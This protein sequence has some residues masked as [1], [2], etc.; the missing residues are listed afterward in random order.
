MSNDLTQLCNDYKQNI[1][2]DLTDVDNLEEITNDIYLVYSQIEPILDLDKIKTIIRNI[3]LEAPVIFQPEY[4]DKDI[5]LLTKQI[6]ELKKIKQPEQRT[7]EWH[8]F[9]NN[10]LTASDLGTALKKNKYSTR[11]KLVAKK[12]GYEEP[13]V[14]GEAIRHG[15]KYEDVAIDIYARRNN[16]VVHEYGCIPHPTLPY[17]GA[18]P[19]GICD[20]SSNNKNYIGR[21]LE[22]KCPKSRPITGIIPEHY[23][24]QVQGQLEVCELQYCDYLEC[25][26]KEYPGFI[27]FLDD[28]QETIT[29]TKNNMEKGIIIELY[30][31]KDKKAFYF[32]LNNFNSQKDIEKWE[33]SKISTIFND[34]NIEYTGTTYWYL[35]KYSCVLVE[36]DIPRFNTIKEHI[37]TFWDDVLKYREIGFESLITKKQIIK[38]NKETKYKFFKKT[39]ELTFLPDS[40]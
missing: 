5:Q 7:P 34:D 16:V 19:D 6:N 1:D 32:Y 36:R 21:M 3:L 30:N 31:I 17:F 18:S 8:T 28:S 14:T 11:Q 25:S 37:K 23:E 27:E 40:S 22:I 10:R 12:C 4:N 15:V 29:K 20:Y 24:L 33:D 13:F 35:E 9:R 39:E 26:I 2:L 38:E